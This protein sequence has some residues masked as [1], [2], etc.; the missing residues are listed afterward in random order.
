[1][2]DEYRCL[3]TGCSSTTNL[4]DSIGWSVTSSGEWLCPVH[5]QAKAA[6]DP[7]T[8]FMNNKEAMGHIRSGLDTAFDLVRRIRQTL[9]RFDRRMKNLD[10]S[11][12]LSALAAAWSAVAS[13]GRAKLTLEQDLREEI[14]RESRA[15]LA[16][17]KTRQ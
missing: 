9:T 13:D 1:M 11:A 12:R 15:V 7:M 5:A 10:R 8:A 17:R 16:Q 2:T 4:R 14:E 6:P 3:E